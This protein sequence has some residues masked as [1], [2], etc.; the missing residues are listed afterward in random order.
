VANLITLSRST[1]TMIFIRFR[2]PTVP[3]TLYEITFDYFISQPQTKT[4]YRI[5]V[6]NS[7]GTLDVHWDSGATQ[8]QADESY[9]AFPSASA[10][11]IAAASCI[12]PKF[13]PQS[14]PAYGQWNTG[15]VALRAHSTQAAFLMTS[16][17][18]GGMQWKNFYIRAKDA[19]WCPDAA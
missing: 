5:G 10:K 3:G 9:T 11:D 18:V 1:S 12:K 8:L 16:E 14:P 15:K 2:F 6:G 13:Q 19:S 17:G 7:D 4:S